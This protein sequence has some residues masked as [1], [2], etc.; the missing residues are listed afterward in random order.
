MGPMTI[1]TTVGR[2]GASGPFYRLNYHPPPYLVHAMSSQNSN[3]I[4]FDRV[5]ITSNLHRDVYPA[6][7][8]GL[9]RQLSAN[10]LYHFRSILGAC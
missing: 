4:N 10:G 5:N 8:N 1:K 2:Q 9:H 7:R 6:V 3:E